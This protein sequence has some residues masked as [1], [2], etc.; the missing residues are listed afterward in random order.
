MKAWNTELHESPMQLKIY[1]Q[2]WGAFWYMF[3]SMQTIKEEHRKELE[4]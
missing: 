2:L 3:I 1:F 4:H